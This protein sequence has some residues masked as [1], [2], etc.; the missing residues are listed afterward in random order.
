MYVHVADTGRVIERQICSL[1]VV[2]LEACIRQSFH[3]IGM[4]S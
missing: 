1:R 3:R 2:T 4:T